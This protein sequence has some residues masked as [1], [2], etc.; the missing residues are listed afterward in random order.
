MIIY[1]EVCLKNK[2]L[3]KWEMPL[4]ILHKEFPLPWDQPIDVVEVV[5]L[6]KEN[7]EL[8]EEIEKLEEYIGKLSKMRVDLEEKIEKS[9]KVKR[10]CITKIFELQ[11]SVWSLKNENEKLKERIVELE[12][13]NIE[14]ENKNDDLEK[15]LEELSEQL[16]E[17]P[18]TKKELEFIKDHCGTARDKAR[19]H[20]SELKEIGWELTYYAVEDGEY[21]K[22]YLERGTERIEFYVYRDL[23]K[24]ETKANMQVELANIEAI[25]YIRLSNF[26]AFLEETF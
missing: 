2:D 21:A 11:N 17:A 6:N 20:V 22:V 18:F 1:D 16:I 7:K 8:E 5:R 4:G 14:I 13:E 24:D 26:A 10:G 3:K 19:K 15:Q 9:N 23:D 12:R 25:D